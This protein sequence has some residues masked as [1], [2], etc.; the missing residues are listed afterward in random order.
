MRPEVRVDFTFVIAG[1]DPAIH[2]FR[3]HKIQDVDA[4]N[5]CGHDGAL[6]AWARLVPRLSPP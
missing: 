4:R 2:V 6:C 3:S 1:L 5:E